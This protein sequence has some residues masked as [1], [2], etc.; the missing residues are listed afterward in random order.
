M[1]DCGL[2][3]LAVQS[4]EHSGG[5]RDRSMP[6]I[7]SGSKRI[8]I[9]VVDEVHRRHWNPGC[10]AHLA[11]HINKEAMLLIVMPDAL[12]KPGILHNAKFGI[13]AFHR[14]EYEVVASVRAIRHVGNCEQEIG[15]AH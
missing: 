12:K 1:R 15:R 3:L 2:E 4:L 5:Y 14:L 9:D 6:W 11:H 13:V 8:R 10:Y 7:A